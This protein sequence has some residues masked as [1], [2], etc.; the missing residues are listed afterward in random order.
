MTHR[1]TARWSRRGEFV[2]LRCR[3][4]HCGRVRAVIVDPLPERS[5]K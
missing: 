1:C 3:D 2:I 4:P 5:V